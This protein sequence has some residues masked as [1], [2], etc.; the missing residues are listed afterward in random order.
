MTKDEMR[1]HIVEQDKEIFSLIA[2]VIDV[3]HTHSLW[4]SED[5]YTF[6]NGETWHR[7]KPD[8]DYA[9]NVGKLGDSD[10]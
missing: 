5:E 4:G 1:L 8:E 9:I 6:S 2:L 10:E 3:I 7:F